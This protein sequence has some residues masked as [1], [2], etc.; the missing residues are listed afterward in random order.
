MQLGALGLGRLRE[1]DLSP[2][3]CSN[4]RG[5]EEKLVVRGMTLKSQFDEIKAERGPNRMS[6]SS[7]A[8]PEIHHPVVHV[9]LKKLKPRLANTA[10]K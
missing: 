5:E 9:D 7:P 3:R 8:G 2:R 6:L 10:M 1:S 4:S